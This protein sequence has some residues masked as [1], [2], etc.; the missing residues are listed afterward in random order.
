MPGTSIII[1]NLA[2]EDFVAAEGK[3]LSLANQIKLAILN[4]PPVNDEDFVHN[5][6]NWTN[7]PFLYRI[8]VI[9]KTPA[10]AS[11][12]Y[13][14]LESAYHSGASFRLL[15]TVKLS[16]Q[17]NLLKRSRL[18]DALDESSELRV[19]KSLENFR[20]FH[21]LGGLQGEYQE[22]EPKHFDAYADLERL[23]IDLSLV[24][25]EEQM[26]LLK[27]ALPSKD[28]SALMSPHPRMG[29]SK[30]ITTTLFEPPK[31]LLV[32]NGKKVEDAPQS[33]SITLE[34][35]F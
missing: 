19:S 15:K 7:L 30:S 28:R 35:T 11:L 14:F 5:V 13:K 33:P 3:L 1:S 18:A 10:A 17:E 4:L 21:N 2:R 12:A 25:N 8:I 26:D 32:T 20:N 6:T 29:R 23:G 34:E 9:F 31:L 16:L 27:L 24:N 22:P